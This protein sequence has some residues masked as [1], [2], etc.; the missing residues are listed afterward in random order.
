VRLLDAEQAASRQ[1]ELEARVVALE[2][3]L[4]AA[5][6]EA[7]SATASLEDLKARLR[8]LVDDA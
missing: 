7:A 8:S 1:G 4:D 5:R 6:T 2:A 3:E